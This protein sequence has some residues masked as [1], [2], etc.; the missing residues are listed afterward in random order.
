[1]FKI[2]LYKDKQYIQHVQDDTGR[3]LAFRSY[4]EADS[5]GKQVKASHSNII[6]Y[7]MEKV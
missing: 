4:L 3:D 1:M 6:R 2:K 5:F 7:V